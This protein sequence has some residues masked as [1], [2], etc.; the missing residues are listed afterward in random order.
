VLGHNGAN[1]QGKTRRRTG[2]REGFELSKGF[3]TL[4]P[5]QGRFW[6]QRCP[7]PFCKI[8]FLGI[9][10]LLSM[11]VCRQGV[12]FSFAIPHAWDSSARNP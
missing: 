12:T 2:V 4:M 10:P 8:L 11:A 7:R 6:I 1:P 3:L 5:E 9:F